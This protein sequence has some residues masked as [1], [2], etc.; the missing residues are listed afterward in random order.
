MLPKAALM[1]KPHVAPPL[2]SLVILKPKFHQVVGLSTD[3]RCAYF[4]KLLQE[5]IN[6]MRTDSLIYMQLF[7]LVLTFSCCT[8]LFSVVFTM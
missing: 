3:Q 8:L 2:C 7:P 6:Q 1:C 4:N 5:E